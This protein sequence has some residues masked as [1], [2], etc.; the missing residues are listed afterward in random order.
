[1][2]YSQHNAN[3]VSKKRDPVIEEGKKLKLDNG[4]FKK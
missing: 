3:L 1:M 2:I 4:L